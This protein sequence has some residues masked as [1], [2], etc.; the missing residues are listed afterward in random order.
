M[1][2]RTLVDSC[3]L[4]SLLLAPLVSAQADPISPSGFD[5][6]EALSSNPNPLGV[7]EPLARYLQIH[8]DLP[9]QPLTVRG[10]AFRRNADD[11]AYPAYSVELDLRM[12]VP[13]TS[14]AAP[15]AD[16]VAN[17][18]RLQALVVARRRVDFNA[19]PPARSMPQPFDYRVPFD[20]PFVVPAGRACWEM[21]VFGRDNAG[22]VHFD[23]VAPGAG[24]SNPLPAVLVH[25]RGCTA[26]RQT[27]PFSVAG[28][29]QMDW[30]HGVAR[31]SFGAT[32]GPASAVAIAVLGFDSQQW[33]GLPL[34]LLVPSSAGG[35]SGPCFVHNDVVVTLVG[36]TDAQGT[37]FSPQVTLPLHA[38]L[39]GATIFH[40]VWALD[41]EANSIGIVTSSG[42]GRQ[43]VAPYATPAVS[44]VG[45]RGALAA[46]G[47]VNTGGGLVTRF[48][49]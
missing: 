38:G 11:G 36:T 42:M 14:A 30:A 47:V 13:L 43:I 7:N 26:T 35:A 20:A 37:Y 44:L 12:S 19:S 24:D 48:V 45:V 33:A 49:Q 27:S 18:G 4:P 31:M 32:L 25:G 40:H 15:S 29:A 28:S 3:L 17:H 39:H 10:L 2:L 46:S 1:T 8:E 34:P 6:A 9:A 16:F 22:L 41:G 21:Q 23:Q 5:V